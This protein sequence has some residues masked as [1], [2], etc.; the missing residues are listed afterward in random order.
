MGLNSGNSRYS[1]VEI[2]SNLLY[3]LVNPIKK[4]GIANL[5]T[6]DIAKHMDLSKAT[7]YKYFDSKDDVIKNFVRLFIKYYVEMNS[8]LDD[9]EGDYHSRY[10]VVFQKMLMLANFGSEVFMQDLRALY[11][12]LSEVLQ[13]A[14]SERNESLRRFYQMGM[15]EGVFI[16]TNPELFILQDEACFSK[17]VDPLFLLGRNMTIRQALIDYYFLRVRQIFTPE[18]CRKDTNEDTLK[19][20]ETMC[21]K[22]TSSM[23]S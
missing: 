4:I 10:L 18:F 14:L 22:I 23:Q 2:K 1:D 21:Q 11:P 17:L 7:L 13:E 8:A 5:R 16:E 12:D 15:D 3:R 6:D 19:S 20:L 9:S